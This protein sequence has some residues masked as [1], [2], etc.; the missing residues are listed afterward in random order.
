MYPV[1]ERLATFDG[2][3]IP[4]TIKDGLARLGIRPHT[5]HEYESLP[6]V[7]HPTVL[8]HEFTD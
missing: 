1:G 4:L 8:D 7:F 6:Y 5:D 2:Y 3:I